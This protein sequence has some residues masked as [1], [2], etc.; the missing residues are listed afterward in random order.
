[1]SRGQRGRDRIEEDDETL[2]L[3]AVDAHDP[4]G[5]T[6]VEDADIV[7]A[8]D[9][10]APDDDGEDEAASWDELLE[11]RGAAGS[12]GDDDVIDLM[13]TPD[14]PEPVTEAQ[15]AR[16]VPLREGQEFV[17]RSCHLVKPRT[18]LADAS[19]GLC[20]DCI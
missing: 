16:A 7:D 15:H 17:C 20:R 1:M 19:R 3:E 11:R 18:Q 10:T 8:E 14:P 12:E 6:E 2:G 5:D 4:G 13:S 9:P